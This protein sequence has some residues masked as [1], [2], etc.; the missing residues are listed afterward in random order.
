MGVVAINFVEFGSLLFQVTKNFRNFQKMMKRLLRG[1]SSRSSKDKQSEE[2]KK[3]KY[4]LP[5][6]ME[7][8]PTSSTTSSNSTYIILPDDIYAYWER[9]RSPEPEPEPSPDPYR[10]FVYQWDL[11]EIAKQWHPEDPPQYTGEDHFDPWA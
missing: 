2:N 8:S 11:E 4:N 10:Q 9:T 5:R 1:C 7:A 3:P 6:T